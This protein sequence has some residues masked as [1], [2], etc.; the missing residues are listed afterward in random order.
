ML[1]LTLRPEFRGKTLK[2]TVIELR[3][4]RSTGAIDKSAT[5][6]LD[7][8]YPSIDLLRMAEA[9]Q[10]DKGRTIVLKGGRGQGKSHM[11]ATA[12]HLLSD[13]AAAGQ[14]RDYWGDRL[15]DDVVKGLAFREGFQLIA[16]ALHNQRY[17]FLWDPI[18]EQHP[19]GEYI[20]GKWEARDTPVP[21]NE[22]MVELFSEKPT[23]LIF[24]EFQTWYDG[25]T[26]T[27]QHPRR[28]WAFN[29]IQTLSEVAENH[30]DKLALIVS[31]RDGNTEA[32]QQIHRVNPLV[33][34]FT[35]PLVK[36][37]RRR[38]LLYR[39]FENRFNISDS[40][41]ETCMGTH[42]SEYCRIQQ[43]PGNEVE[44]QKQDFVETW[45]FSPRLLQLLDDQVLMASEAQ[46]TRDLIKLLVETFKV[47]GDTSPVLTAADFNID[48]DRSAVGSLIDSVANQ[49]HRDLRE[50]ALRNLQNIKETVADPAM[51]VPHVTEVISS[52]WL[53][54]LTVD[55]LT[56]ALPADLQIDITRSK[57]ID[58]NAFRVELGLIR[59]GSF[60]LHDTG[61]RLV[62]KNE[63]N[64]ETKLLASARNNKLF[65]DGSDVEYLAKMIHSLLA[66]ADHSPYRIIVLRK[67]W[68]ANPWSELPEE[69][70]PKSWDN[71]I[72]VIVIPE[73]PDN[74]NERLGSWLAKNMDQKR[75]T[76]RFLLPHKGHANVFFNQDILI[77]A[78]AAKLAAD[79]K[80]NDKE[81]AAMQAKFE[82]EVNNKL[83]SY[84][85]AFCVLDIW[86]FGTPKNCQFQFAKH[87]KMGSQIPAGIHDTV[88]ETHFIPEEFEDVV[89]DF[90]KRNASLADLLKELQEP[91]SGGKHSIPW[92]G[93]AEIK[94]YLERMI[95]SGN[96]AVNVRGSTLVQTQPGESED[97]AYPR[98]RGKLSNV[99][100]SHMAQTTLHEPGATG[101]AGGYQPTD[102]AAGSDGST[103]N[104]PPPPSNPFIGGGTPTTLPATGGGGSSISG[105]VPTSSH[106]SDANSPLN[107]LGE[108]ERW[109]VSTATKVQKIEIGTAELTGKQLQEMIRKLPDGRYSLK[110]E[111]E[112]EV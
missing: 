15:K 40:D 95:A 46:E 67:S 55:R 19:K 66:G 27:K 108:I 51:D 25:L 33:I 72:P 112:E 38:L 107:L 86:D 13:K 63:E 81:F 2:G 22:D 8:T 21:S 28:N 106:T 100:G 5:E 1:N 71:R 103:V 32:Y 54:S 29:F 26:N 70:H 64:N 12:Y 41:I 23:V 85:P 17:K 74:E 62:F 39:M 7:I 42:F 65:Q 20:R 31:V 43:V 24:D 105:A 111:K 10:P 75:N 52:L 73:F 91:M 3:D 45:P 98:I 69:D 36:R 97:E 9:I 101:A 78:R 47:A 94:D 18:F 61:G 92:I 90:A 34:D 80:S 14:W 102:P 99:S 53:R 30:P 87:N 93:E 6:F 60:N 49:H 83:K 84:F 58:E 44:K 68:E 104:E 56:G 79:W 50:K 110:I 35:G 89:Q 77:E 16:E 59:E 57:V 82:R 109:G 48:N 76:P 37:D 11:M 4:G 96:L 88:K